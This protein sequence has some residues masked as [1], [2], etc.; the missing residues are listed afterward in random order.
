[1]ARLSLILSVSGLHVIC[2]LA[3]FRPNGQVTGSLLADH[4]RRSNKWP[5]VS[6]ASSRLIE[7]EKD[8]QDIMSIGI[9]KQIEPPNSCPNS[10]CFRRGV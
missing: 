1:M 8:V 5:Y 9:P 7:P 2:T 4:N 3:P 6:L 10:L